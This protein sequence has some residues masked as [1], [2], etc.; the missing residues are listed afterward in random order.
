MEAIR[1][2]LDNVFAAF[3][4]TD[5]VLMFKREMLAGMEEKYNALKEEGKSEHE[6][7][8]SV[9]A[10]FG[11]IDEIAEELGAG[12]GV[13]EPESGI[14]L[15]AAE[16]YAYLEQMRRSSI[17]I[18]IGIWLV[19]AG[20]CAMILI[21]SLTGPLNGAVEDTISAVGVTVLLA[22]V[23]VALPIFIVNGVRIDQYKHY[24]EQKILL[25]MQ[26]QADL[27]QKRTKNNT[28]FIAKLS[29]GVAL[30]LLAV[31]S[32]VLLG[33]LEYYNLPIVSMLFTIG[34]S[35]FLFVTA[36]MGKS[37]FDVVLGKGDY[38]DKAR[39]IKAEKVIGMV[40]SVYWPAI[41]AGYLLWSLVWDAWNISWV[42][43]PVAGVLFG[44]IS[45]GLGAWHYAEKK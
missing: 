10:N 24:N 18:G 22:M 29:I 42:I 11:S 6:A 26:T 27:E 19:I 36:G 15:S 44:G 35:A 12:Q 8:G 14:K 3:P 31:G 1:T 5:R 33:T 7:I 40:S 37:A 41:V 13:S 16:V 20:V 9:I 21:A 30:V 2:Y 25:D 45:G 34:F 39:N 32:F 38:V 28:K 23:A 43:W 4:Q 17:W